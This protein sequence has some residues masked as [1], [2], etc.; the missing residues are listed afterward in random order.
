MI[1]T[2]GLFLL[3]VIG[4]SA[5]LFFT[6][7]T[8]TWF[9]EKSGGE[10]RW[11][12]E[13][14]SG[15][16]EVLL[17]RHF[18]RRRVAADRKTVLQKAWKSWLFGWHV[19]WTMEMPLTA[20]KFSRHSFIVEKTKTIASGNYFSLTNFRLLSLKVSSQSMFSW[21]CWQIL[22]TYYLCTIFWL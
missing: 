21:H 19:L 6:N 4:C 5:R 13:D 3:E 22:C 12:I 14:K 9:S 20:F 15:G 2:R 8:Q 17:D 11:S 7:K 1:E 18:H 16:F 10:Y